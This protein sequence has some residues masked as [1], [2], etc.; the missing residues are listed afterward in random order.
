M[1]IATLASSGALALFSGLVYNRVGFKVG[2]PGLAKEERRAVNMFKAWWHALAAITYVSAGFLLA[3]AFGTISLA[4]FEILLY[5]ELGVICLALWGLTYYLVYLFSGKS[6]LFW[7]MGVF[8]GLL[9]GWLL[10]LILQADPH[11]VTVEKWQVRVEYANEDVL[12]G[13][14]GLV[15]LALFI[16][17]SVAGAIGYFTLFFRTNEPRARYRIGMVS[18]SLI[19]W[20]GSSIV[21]NLLDINE[22][23]WWMLTSRFI[24][25][26]AAL[27]ILMAYQPPA[28]VRRR[29][30]SREGPKPA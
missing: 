5:I 12:G 13:G 2:L 1:V 18:L 22:R 30:A 29:I 10:Y 11:A 8:Y 7:P 6:V 17:P 23:D 26:A 24:S 25:L 16:G 28:W 20:L 9:M 21:A 4:V 15:F 14:F 3:G 19:V 27:V